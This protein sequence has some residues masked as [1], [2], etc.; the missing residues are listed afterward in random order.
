MIK[1][2]IFDI[3]NTMYD[4]DKAHQTGM[5]ALIDYSTSALSIS[6]EGFLQAFRR[7]QEMIKERTGMDCAANHNRLLRFQCIL[8]LLGISAPSHAIRM[9]HAYWDS[10]IAVMSPEPGLKALL[11]A[12]HNKRVPVGVGSDMTAYTQYRKLERLG[13]LDQISQ[14]T[15]SEETV[16]EKPDP[17]FFATCVEKMGCKAS[18]CVFIGDSLKKDALGASACGLHGVWYTPPHKPRFFAT[19]VEKMGCKASECVFIGDSL[20]KDALG[21]SACGLHGVWYTPP[22]KAVQSEADI[23]RI[24]SFDD[25]LQGDK[26]VFGEGLEIL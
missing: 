8:E 21:A 17:R 20:K 4:Y 12:L 11:S 25:C 13:I 9:Y 6:E 10:L 14:I 18:E 16:V 2:V 5:R 3:D 23:A 26:I 22:H 1:A 7:A 15:V 19:C 24:S